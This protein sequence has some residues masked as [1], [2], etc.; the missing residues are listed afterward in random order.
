[1]FYW[2]SFQ[3][4]LCKWRNSRCLDKNGSIPTDPIAF[5]LAK[6]TQRGYWRRWA[7]LNHLAKENK[8]CW[9]GPPMSWV[10]LNNDGASKV[11]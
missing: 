2:L 10:K 5:V 11:I 1:M 7:Y 3:W 6:M 8:V 9:T 4:W